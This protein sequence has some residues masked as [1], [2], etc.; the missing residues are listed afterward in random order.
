DLTATGQIPGTP[1]YL[2]PELAAGADASPA[3]DLYA[4]GAVLFQCVTGRP[5]FGGPTPLSVVLA[6]QRDPVPS[7]R[8]VAPEVPASLAATIQRAL[9]KTPEA[10]FASAEQ[11][12]DAL[13]GELD[14]SGTVPL[15]VGDPHHP[16]GAAPAPA[17]TSVSTVRG[18]GRAA[19]TSRLLDAGG[20]DPGTAH[21]T[22]HGTTDGGAP[23]AA[24]AA[25]PDPDPAYGATQ[26][27]RSRWQRL[28][29]IAAGVLLVGGLLV[30]MVALVTGD[31]DAPE[32]AAQDG[33]TPSQS[34]PP[35]DGDGPSDAEPAPVGAAN[36]QD[37]AAA[38]DEPPAAADEPK[39]ERT[40]EPKPK[41]EPKRTD[42][43]AQ[44]PELLSLDDLIA[45]LSR[46]P[47]AAGRYGDRLLDG[48]ID[49]RRQD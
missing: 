8:E 34:D 9:Q 37:P 14:R 36:D 46:D 21:L 6:H 33:A 42:E 12:R 22:A 11:M 24:A 41:P 30:G 7:L 2:A 17:A 27:G 47:D 13:I 26:E 35:A 15:P 5:P 31:A 29:G 18:S 3:S 49:L 40:D 20:T 23:D 39:P 45:A 43:P 32:Q 28:A 16:G 4:V 48:L 10:R 1:R 25:D 19:A 44:E 38:D